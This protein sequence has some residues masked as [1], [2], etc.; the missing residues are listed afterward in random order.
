MLFMELWQPV[1]NEQ[2]KLLAAIDTNST[3]LQ[4]EIKKEG[5]YLLRLQPELLAGGEY[6]LTIRTGPSLN[7][8]V[9]VAARPRI[10]SFWGDVRDAG[11]RSHEGIDIFGPFRSP[12]LAAADGNITRVTVNNLGGKVVFMRPDD[13]DY[14]LYYAHLDSQM[15]ESG[16]RVKVGDTIGLMG[17][18]GN[19]RTTPPHL[20][21][22]IYGTGGAIDPQPF[23]D[24]KRPDIP[25]IT[26]DPANMNSYV[27][28]S[29]KAVVYHST[30]KKE[31]LLTPAAG[32]VLE[33]RSATGAWYK[34]RLPDGQ[35]GFIAANAV[36]PA[37]QPLRTYKT[38]SALA[39]LDQPHP[40]AAA[41]A[42]VEKGMMLE[43][44][45]VFNQYDYVRLEDQQG[46]VVNR[47]K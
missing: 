37:K 23:V 30:D 39:M 42:T 13:K 20:H 17:N 33:V 4:Y 3:V 12:L 35:E 15:V 2:P 38:D 28:S 11:A 16:Q 32:T 6:T 14:V 22:G 19:A 27:R 26:A 18:T 1:V 47:L 9:A 36:Q 46:W 10:S 29:N 21:F 43:V 31:K 5:E 40:D 34:V 41:R 7:F 45:G 44:L 25:A 24:P 8:P